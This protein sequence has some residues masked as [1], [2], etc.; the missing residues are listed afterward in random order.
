MTDLTPLTFDHAPDPDEVLVGIKRL[1]A[2]HGKPLSNPIDRAWL[3]RENTRAQT[4][5]LLVQ[6]LAMHETRLADFLHAYLAADHLELTGPADDLRNCAESI[7]D[8]A[9]T[10]A[11]E[12]EGAADYLEELK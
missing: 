12:F 8:A 2:D 7:M 1:V 11:R 3:D 10:L 5:V 6:M 4:T 9:E